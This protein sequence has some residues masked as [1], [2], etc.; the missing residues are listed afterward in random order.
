MAAVWHPKPGDCLL[1]NSG[2]VGKHLF[3]I[4]LDTKVGGQHQI[5]SVPVCTARDYARVDDSCLIAPGEHPFVKADSFIQYRDTRIDPIG[6]LQKCV[7][8]GTFTPHTSASQELVDKIRAGL[9]GS[10]FVKRHIKDLLG[11]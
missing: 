1:I 6:H 5:V 4:V 11:C 3:V 10:K 8:E 7:R 2:P 9:A